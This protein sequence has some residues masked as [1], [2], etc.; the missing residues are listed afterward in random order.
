MTSTARLALITSLFA[1][2]A[3]AS[4]C[5]CATSTGPH[6]DAG[7][8]VDIDGNGFDVNPPRPDVGHAEVDAGAD[9]G[10][11]A[12]V[13]RATFCMGRGPA[14]LVGDMQG[15]CHLLDQADGGINGDPRSA[16]ERVRPRRRRRRRI[17]L[18]EILRRLDFRSERPAFDIAHCDPLA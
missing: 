3:I 11:D 6:H 14:V 10:N 16:A 2:A 17:R 5:S 7:M 4:G 15:P 13:D 1:L 12:Y 18:R 8:I 9:V